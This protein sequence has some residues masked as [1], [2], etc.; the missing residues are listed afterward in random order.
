MKLVIGQRLGRLIIRSVAWRDKHSMASYLC[1]CDC[2]NTTIAHSCNLRQGR[3]RSC[4]CLSAELAATR[5]FKHGHAM[6]SK[7]N[8]TTTYAIWSGMITRC[9]STKHEAYKNYGGRGIIVCERWHTFE[10]F[11]SDMGER[12]LGPTEFTLDRIDNDG[13]YEPDNCRWAT[14]KE[15]AA[16]TRRTKRAH[17][18]ILTA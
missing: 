14:R 15:Q 1:D 17:A 7:R 6:T 11:L 18:R 5:G 4:G 16:N 2:G 10:N 8:A 9:E 12:P 13:N 3:T